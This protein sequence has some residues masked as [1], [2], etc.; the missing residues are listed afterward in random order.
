MIVAA[1]SARVGVSH[2]P[3]LLTVNIATHIHRL[4]YL[5]RATPAAVISPRCLRCFSGWGHLGKAFVEQ[6]QRND[7]VCALSSQLLLCT[8]LASGMF[9]QK[10]LNLTFIWQIR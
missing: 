5:A 2:D 7:L 3:H 1:E 10:S 6:C 8:L 9:K 4:S